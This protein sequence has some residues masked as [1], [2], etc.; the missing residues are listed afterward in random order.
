MNGRFKRLLGLSLVVALTAAAPA[1]AGT[2][3]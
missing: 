1:S 3:G 2:G